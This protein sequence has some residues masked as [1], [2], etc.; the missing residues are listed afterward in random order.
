[1]AP[2]RLAQRS[3]R[4]R[5]RPRSA[6]WRDLPVL[7][8]S[9]STYLNQPSTTHTQRALSAWVEDNYPVEWQ[10]AG[11]PVRTIRTPIGTRHVAGRSP[12][13]GYDLTAGINEDKGAS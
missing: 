11:A 13:G 7:P 6:G 4:G 5:P 10:F 3:R 2:H 9:L 1:M 8:T 12:L